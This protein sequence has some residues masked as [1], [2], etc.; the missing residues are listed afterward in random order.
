[1]RANISNLTN[2]IEIL[3]AH[4]DKVMKVLLQ[5]IFCYN[6][7][8]MY[9]FIFK[10]NVFLQVSNVSCVSWDGKGKFIYDCIDQFLA[11]NPVY[12]IKL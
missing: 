1:M 9:F 8:T 10:S 3:F 7:Q 4:I 5:N 12:F 6:E 2:N 11:T